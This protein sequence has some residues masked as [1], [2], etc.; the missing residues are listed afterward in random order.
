MIAEAD[1]LTLA[2]SV[3][4]ERGQ[5]ADAVRGAAWPLNG[6]GA[7]VLARAGFSIGQIA[8]DLADAFSL[9]VEEARG[10]VLRFA[11]YLN[12]LALVNVER[13]EARFRRCADWLFLALKL[14]PAG[15]FPAPVARRQAL[16]TR[17]VPR[18]V[19]TCLRAALPRAGAVAGLV[20]A[21]MALSL[22]VVDGAGIG[23]AM[24]LGLASG[25]GLGLHEAAH[26]AFLRG[27]PSAF[28]TR[29]RRT[30][31]LHTAVGPTRRSVVAIA[32]PLSVALIGVAFSLAGTGL[33]VPGLTIA[34][35]PL[36]AHAFALTVAGG[37]GR[38]ACGI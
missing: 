31:V 4:V 5:L 32:G 14:A 33:A 15:A 24:S 34:G 6:S 35:C 26:A 10:D 9:P 22:G 30:F 23:V 25:L 18:A 3:S 13:R 37:D 7:F 12:A 11:W 2:P 21:G 16:D 27:V 19:G 17:T 36:A 1:M 8:H 38:T 28:V 20:V 29:G